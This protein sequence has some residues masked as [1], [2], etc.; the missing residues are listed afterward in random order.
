MS[1]N[2]GYSWDHFYAPS[3]PP[4]VAYSSSS[5]NYGDSP[6]SATTSL[7][8]EP[9]P[10]TGNATPLPFEPP[11]DL[12]YNSLTNRDIPRLYRAFPDM[13]NANHVH[14]RQTLDQI[15]NQV[16]QGHLPDKNLLNALIYQ[17]QN[18]YICSVNTCKRH[19]QPWARQDRAREHI[20]TDHLGAYFPCIVP[21]WWVIQEETRCT[22]R[23]GVG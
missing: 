21:E 15:V 7:S 22:F 6:L 20:L 1:D 23:Q 16:A 18:G 5:S 14:A 13:S 4:I 11:L 2:L 9:G 17:V 8:D 10:S 19:I 3:S 12:N